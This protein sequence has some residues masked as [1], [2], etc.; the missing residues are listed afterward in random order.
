MSW[1]VVS[2]LGVASASFSTACG[3]M[4]GT[5]WRSP[6]MGARSQAASWCGETLD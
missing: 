5:S 3:P 1:C 2:I 4:P 6:V